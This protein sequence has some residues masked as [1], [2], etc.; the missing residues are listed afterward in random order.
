MK[1]VV[2]YFPKF[3]KEFTVGSG[4]VKDIHFSGRIVKIIFDN[5]NHEHISG[6]PFD[7]VSPK[8]EPFSDRDLLPPT[9]CACGLAWKHDG[10]HKI[11]IS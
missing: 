11:L 5:G 6:F 3:E 2:V 1:K 8:P 4:G 10:P 7:F 9:E